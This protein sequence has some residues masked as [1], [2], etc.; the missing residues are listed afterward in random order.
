L[1][2]A[3]NT[4]L[5]ILS[6]VVLS[7]AGGTLR[8]PSLILDSQ[9]LLTRV[10]AGYAYNITVVNSKRK[11]LHRVRAP[12]TRPFARQLHGSGRA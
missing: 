10:R 12:V 11:G 6:L 2:Y 3:L 5:R 7:V 9:A 4:G 1:L 8:K